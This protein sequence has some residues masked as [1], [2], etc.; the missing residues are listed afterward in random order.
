M[1][2]L[3][4]T[5]S[6]SALSGGIDDTDYYAIDLPKAGRVGLNFKFPAGLGTG[7]TY[8]VSIYNANGTNLY[9]FD[10]DGSA[11]DGTWLASQGTF[12]PAGRAYIKIYGYSGGWASW[13]KTYTLNTTLTAGT[14][15][16]EPNSSTSAATVVPLGATISGSTLSGSFDDTD[17]YAIDLPKAGR[18]GLNFKFPA[19]LGTGPP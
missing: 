15:E 12:L 16:L 4:T 1:V 11:A 8:T 14:V 2:P 17:Y 19:G 3:G 10:L 6:G 13:G 5:V 18:V 9:N 7:P